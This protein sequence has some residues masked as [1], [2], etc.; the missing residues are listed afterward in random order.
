MENGSDSPAVLL[1]AGAS[2]NAFEVYYDDREVLNRSIASYNQEF[3][4]KQRDYEP[5]EYTVQS[6]ALCDAVDQVLREDNSR[7]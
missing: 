4:R 2:C 5:F 1:R 7:K 3:P 6:M